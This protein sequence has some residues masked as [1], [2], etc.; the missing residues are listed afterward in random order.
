MVSG[1][2]FEFADDGAG[3]RRDGFGHDGR[4]I[5]DLVLPLRVGWC[6]LVL[7]RHLVVEGLQTGLVASRGDRREDRVG[8]NCSDNEQRQIRKSTDTDNR[9]GTEKLITKNRKSY[10]FQYYEKRFLK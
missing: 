5:V 2:G 1:M 3:C 4:G 7:V 6:W 8:R 10:N 9:R